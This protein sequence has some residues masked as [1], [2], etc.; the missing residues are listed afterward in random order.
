[1]G[2]IVVNNTSINAGK[3]GPESSSSMA[4]H[5]GRV[6]LASAMSIPEG[7]SDRLSLAKI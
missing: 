3:A 2:I 1:M 4:T 5:I 7:I 6:F